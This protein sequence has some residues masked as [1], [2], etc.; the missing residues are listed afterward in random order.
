M[1]YIK[2][3][4]L[5]ESVRFIELC[6]VYYLKGRIDGHTYNSLTGI[7]L[8]FIRDILKKERIDICVEKKI[9]EKINSLFVVDKKINN[10]D[11]KVVCLKDCYV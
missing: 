5:E 3:R 9:L 7:K 8:N 1:E 10:L 2:K 11:R 4:L 6:Q